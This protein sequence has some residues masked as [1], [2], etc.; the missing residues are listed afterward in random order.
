MDLFCIKSASLLFFITFVTCLLLKDLTLLGQRAR[1]QLQSQSG[2]PLWA[3][4]L[5]SVNSDTASE[6]TITYTD[7][8]DVIVIIC[9]PTFLRY[10]HTHAFFRK[11]TSTSQTVINVPYCSKVT[12][13]FLQIKLKWFSFI[14]VYLQTSII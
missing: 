6:Y 2:V 12:A 4:I 5:K 13:T 1:Y 10:S 14:D 11:M 3:V 8:H 7:I 9:R